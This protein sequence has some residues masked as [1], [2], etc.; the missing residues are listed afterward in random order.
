[1][2]IETTQTTWSMLR[3]ENQK[4]TK[5]QQ[6]SKPAARS[7]PCQTSWMECF[8]KIINV[9]QPLFIFAKRPIHSKRLS[10]C[11]IS[12]EISEFCKQK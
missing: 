4:E 11:S 12:D 1:M 2:K 6:K 3:K 7:K 9:F 10:K 5:Q 8:A